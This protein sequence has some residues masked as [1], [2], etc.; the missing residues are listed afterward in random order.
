[1]NRLS[2]ASVCI[3]TAIALAACGGDS[4]PTGTS[5]VPPAV[6]VASLVVTP[7]TA[8][9][10]VGGTVTFAAV[11]KDAQGRDLAGRI[12]TWTSDAQ[13]V[14]TVSKAGV[15]TAVGA[16][17]ARITATSEG[18]SADATFTVS[19]IP[20]AAVVLTPSTGNV[21]VGRTLAIT[22]VAKDD[23]GRDLTGRLILRVESRAMRHG[24][25]S[26]LGSAPVSI[27]EAS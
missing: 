26:A 15:A 3:V 1:M 14:A 13:S 20:V 6:Q 4:S 10:P 16:G 5:N 12:I 21:V 27:V 17:S 18:K 25:G 24:T 8:N 23:Q 22:A 2:S 7:A 19:P 9:S 11:A